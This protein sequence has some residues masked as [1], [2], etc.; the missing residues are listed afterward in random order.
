[1]PL[2]QEILR[3]S[4]QYA[5]SLSPSIVPS[6]S[7]FINTLVNSNVARY[8]PFKLLDS[9]GMYSQDTDGTGKVKAV[10]GSK[11]DVFKN[12][13][14][15]LSQK[16]K[17]MKFLLNTSTYEES[18]LEEQQRNRPFLEYLKSRD[19]GLDKEIAEAITYALALST[20]SEGELRLHAF[21][22]S[23]FMLL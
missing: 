13:E 9:V 23:L 17:L 4:R 2:P 5:I 21:I 11:E 19:I 12:K 15:G 14:L 7:P 18:N 3:Q 10:P 20:S 16:R 22:C 6:V 1:M 8:V